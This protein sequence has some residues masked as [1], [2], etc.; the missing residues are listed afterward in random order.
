MVSC[1][2]I[3]IMWQNPSLSSHTLWSLQDF[4]EL[5]RH[6]EVLLNY[7]PAPEQAVHLIRGK[8]SRSHRR[9]FLSY[10]LIEFWRMLPLSSTATEV[11]CAGKL[12][13][14]FT[15][16]GEF[17]GGGC[18]TI[19]IYLFLISTKD[20]FLWQSLRPIHVKRAEHEATTRSSQI[21]T[22]KQETSQLLSFLPP[23]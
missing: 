22:W 16:S 20:L 8:S 18:R 4:E 7:L 14:N 15:S 3:L 23:F 5:T 12:S 6:P 21:A 1:L 9:M 11:S 17:A 19:F 2:I 10:I 13:G